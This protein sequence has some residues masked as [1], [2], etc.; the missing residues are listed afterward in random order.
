M[1]VVIRPFFTPNGKYIYD[2]ETNSILAVN[3]NEYNSFCRIC[4]M[5]PSNE[6]LQVLEF[7]QNKGF[8]RE[9]LLENIEHPQDRFLEFH[10]ENKI[11]KITLQVTQNCN[12][13]CAYCCYTGDKY[14]NREHSNKTMTYEIMQKSVDFLM[15]HSTSSETVDLGFYGG[16]PLLEFENIKTL[17]AYI[18]QKY[19][20]KKITYSMTT[21]GTM[22]T[23]ENIV[24]LQDK[25]FNIMISLDGPKELHDIN[26]VF[27]NGQGSFDKIMDNVLYIKNNYPD[28]YR[29]IGFNAVV[30]PGVDFKCINDF[31]SA[32]EVIEDNNLR[33]GIMNDY[34]IEE[35]VPYDE[36]YFINYKI[37]RSK[38]LLWALGFINKSH[39]SGMFNAETSRLLRMYK[40]FGKTNSLV[41]TTHPG[42]PC[43]PG[44]KRP[45]VDVDGNLFPCERV[46]EESAI[47]QIGNVFSGFDVN[48]VRV[49]LNPGK[50]TADKCK[51]CWNFIHCGM[52]AAA[53]DNTQELVGSKKLAR[54]SMVMSDTL[55]KFSSICLLKENS[56]DFEN[57]EE[58]YYV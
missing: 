37:Q 57:A 34:Y 58:G 9:S 55:E 41:K 49:V 6:D 36:L 48:K 22:F 50:L 1:S 25:E 26:R 46:S 53:A 8:C 30:A 21:N 31:F 5:N 15:Q 43:I 56:F 51:D 42:G 44:A 52:C 32:S 40:G 14:S 33:V 38:W 39:V 2:R 4:E 17:I 3:D 19:P 28:F 24:F 35:P 13:R 16:E 10:L 18:E 23:D 7:Y 54:C 11:E 29:R 47:M 27:V 45:M 20:Y 12:L